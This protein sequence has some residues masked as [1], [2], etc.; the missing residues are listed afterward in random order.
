[1][2]LFLAF[3]SS[4]FLGVYDLFKKHSL[5]GNAVFPVLFWACASAAVLFIPI[6][7][8]SNFH[9]EMM[10]SIHL[11]VPELTHNEHILV[12]L[13]SMLVVASWI[14]SFFALK[15]LPLT[16]VS[17]IR[18]TG[19]LWT[20]MGAIIIYGEHLSPLQWLGIGITLVSFYLFSTV[21]KLEGLS[22]R[23]NRWLWFII[24]GTLL[25]AASGLYDKYLLQRINRM[26][27]QVYFT[28]YQV[29]LLLPVILFFWYPKRRQ[30]PFKWRNSIPF[31][32][33]FL[34][35]ADFAYFYALSDPDSL[36]SLVSALRRFGVV[37]PFV[38]GA[39]VYKERNIKKKGQYLAGIILGVLL[40]LLA[41]P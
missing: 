37:I 41:K 31:I 25:G 22:F 21:G 1:M 13:K 9:P 24:A 23:S 8:L 26:S 33:I 3:I 5:N 38:F 29:L 36:I 6:H 7:F 4:L 11:Y 34:I 30:V 18:S 35:I 27:V 39:V 10:K 16:I 40:I 15:H 20:L 19:P 2:W 14:F 32:G 28:Y 17:P 12:F